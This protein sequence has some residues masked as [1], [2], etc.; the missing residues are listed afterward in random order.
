MAEQD[1]DESPDPSLRAPDPSGEPDAPT[2]TTPG[3]G[4]G[5]PEFPGT[6]VSAALVIGVLLTILAIVVAVQ[7]TASISVT[8]LAWEFDAPLFA[9]ILAAIVAGVLLDETLGFFWRRRRRRQLAEGAEL[10]RLRRS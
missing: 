4:A 5:T 9:V 7:N 1:A 10:R 8:F 2:P 3:G 6:G